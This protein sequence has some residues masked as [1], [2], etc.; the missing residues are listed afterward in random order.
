MSALPKQRE[1]SG[2]PR[3]H[4][5]QAEHG[6][7]IPASLA[8]A[9][10]G[11]ETYVPTLP[12]TY[13]LGR[14]LVES[15]VARFAPYFFARFALAD[16]WA[17][18]CHS[19]AAHR[20]YVVG[21]LRAA[22]GVPIPVPAKAI[23]AIRAFSPVQPSKPDEPY[24]YQPGQRVTWTLAGA[25]RD[26]VFVEYVGARSMVRTWIFGAERVCEVRAGE[27]EPQDWLDIRGD[28]PQKASG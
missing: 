25:R 26:A 27:L 12:R 18:L 28:Q 6:R 16:H 17:E 9:E 23:D 24:V 2:E 1:A 5:V 20:R 19:R 14:R 15:T 22:D 8:V 11:F 7:E 10:L 21:V 13:R 3:W 4:V